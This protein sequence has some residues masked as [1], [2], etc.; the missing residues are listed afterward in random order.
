MFFF[1][2]IHT[3]YIDNEQFAVRKNGHAMRRSLVHVIWV[4]ALMLIL[5][6]EDPQTKTNLQR[7]QTNGV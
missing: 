3:L 2:K 7:N 4:R 1:T 6:K 5:Y